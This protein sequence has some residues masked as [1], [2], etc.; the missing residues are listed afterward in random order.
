MAEDVEV[1][2]EGLYVRTRD[3]R[4]RPER[5]T[6]AEMGGTFE[7]RDQ[8]YLWLLPVIEGNVAVEFEFMSLK[9]NG[10]SMVILQASGMH[11]ESFL[12]DWPRRTNGWMNTVYGENVRNYHWEFFREMDDCRTDVASHVLV[13]NPWLWPL[14]YQCQ[15]RLLELNRWHKLQFIQEGTHLR[16][17]INGEQVIDCID[18]DTTGHGPIYRGG[19]VGIRCMWKS[20]FMFRHLKVW[21]K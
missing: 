2:K 14:H 17:A 1:K 3:T 5:E 21:Q 16:G 7:D 20:A 18:T 8:V 9:E 10:L 11:G 6:V 4:S 12:E 15:D 13:K 19:N